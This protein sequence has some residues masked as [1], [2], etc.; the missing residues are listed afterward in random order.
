[1][2]DRLTYS[3]RLEA[4]NS[5]SYYTAISALTDQW[6]AHAQSVVGDLINEFQ[7]FRRTAGL[8]EHSPAEDT[9]ELLVLGVLLRE[10]SR[11]AAGL[12]AW[13][14][15]LL[16][17]LVT[18][19][20]R[21]PWA[22]GM[23]KAV[24][25]FI[26]GLIAPREWNGTATPKNGQE[27]TAGD[28]AVTCLL[29]WLRA[30][31]Q[32]TQADRLAVWLDY[33]KTIG[34]ERA[35][36]AISQSLALAGNFARESEAALGQYT[37]GVESFRT[38]VKPQLRFRY[39]SELVL[40][41]R[42]EYHLGMLGTELLNRSYRAPF[43]ATPHKIV[44]VPPCL[45]TRPDTG[46]AEDRCQ[47]LQTPLGAKC[48][49]CEPNCRI[50]QLTRLGEKAGFAVYSIPDDELQKVCLASGKTG[51]SIGVVG[52]SCAL[53]NWSAGWEADRLGL[54]AQGLLL[55]YVGCRQHWCR[56]G[57]STDANFNKLQELMGMNRS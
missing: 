10:H 31:G 30:H 33:L 49:G 20:D 11:H 43:L 56:H 23:I 1:M 15:H 14:A 24:R 25:G 38:A 21:W 35:Q 16:A 54:P 52:L 37:T 19:Q 12:P 17:G 46:P 36:A 28:G 4:R 55:D 2:T 50:H 34:P 27:A 45:R 57:C 42:L 13:T 48:Q 40:R 26:G 44:I 18:W 9:F 29:H 41:T 22:E 32:G 3:L 7:R 51:G 39:D 8:P 6:L 47:A 5:N 53:T